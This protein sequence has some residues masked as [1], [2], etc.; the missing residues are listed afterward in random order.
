[1]VEHLP[2]TTCPSPLSTAGSTYNSFSPSLVGGRPWCQAGEAGAGLGTG[3]GLRSVLRPPSPPK[4]APALKT[5]LAGLGSTESSPPAGPQ[6]PFSMARSLKDLDYPQA[7]RHPAKLWPPCHPTTS[8]SHRPR[9]PLLPPEETPHAPASGL[10]SEPQNSPRFKARPQ[11][12]TEHGPQAGA[13][14]ITEQAPTPGTH[15]A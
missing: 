8:E 12:R 11:L 10:S 15:A 9:P 14:K 5:H 1:M 2:P 6:T 3:P 13:V 7:P 4:Q